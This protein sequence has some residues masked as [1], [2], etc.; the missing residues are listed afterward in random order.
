MAGTSGAAEGPSDQHSSPMSC[1]ED[2]N[3]MVQ[4][5]RMQQEIDDVLRQAKC[6]QR[7]Q[8]DRQSGCFRD[9]PAANATSNAGVRPGL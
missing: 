9:D 2:S 4:T 3:P 6:G 7:Q 5:S 8:L 1:S